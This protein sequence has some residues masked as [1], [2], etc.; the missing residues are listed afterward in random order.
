MKDNNV[1]LISNRIFSDT[2]PTYIGGEE[3]KFRVE[4]DLTGIV[5]IQTN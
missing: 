4:D 1:W 3:Y 2:S 5:S